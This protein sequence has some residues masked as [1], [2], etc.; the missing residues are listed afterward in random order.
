M[1]SESPEMKH[2]QKLLEDHQ[3]LKDLLARIE[4]ALQKRDL[5][6]PEVG[7]LLGELGDRL[8]KHFE[9]EEQGGYF[10]EA[11]LQAPRLVARANELLAQHPKMCTQADKLLELAG[12]EE[13]AEGWWQKTR[14]RFL[15]FKEEVMRHESK[16]DGLLQEAYQQDI[17]AN[18]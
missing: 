2:H 13:N 8:V 17:G 9:L 3:A 6:I 11:L 12:A 14:E 4:R 10:A 1:P 15:A 5:P 18:D 16:E 7:K